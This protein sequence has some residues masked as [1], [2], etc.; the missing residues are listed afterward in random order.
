MFGDSRSITI[1]DH[2]HSDES[3]ARFITIGRSD[4]ITILVVVHEENDDRIRI[5]NARSANAL[6]RKLYEG[7]D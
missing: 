4:Q 7:D 3:E 6:E 1:A 2:R 5:I